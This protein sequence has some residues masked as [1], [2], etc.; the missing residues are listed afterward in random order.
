MALH[1]HLDPPPARDGPHP[2]I[3]NVAESAKNPA[4]RAAMRKGARTKGLEGM[5][6]NARKCGYRSRASPEKAF[7]Q[8]HFPDCI[9]R[10]PGPA[11]RPRR[12]CLTRL[13]PLSSSPL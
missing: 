12:D 2:A 13:P 6:L 11:S 3:S 8:A 5:V 10:A 1:P 9:G 4:R 7:G